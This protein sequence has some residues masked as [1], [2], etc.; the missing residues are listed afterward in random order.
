MWKVYNN[1]A[2]TDQQIGAVLAQLEEDGLLEETIIFFYADH[3]GPLPRQKRLIYDSG[4]KVPLIIRFPE[5]L[6][7]GIKDDQLVSFVERERAYLISRYA[8]H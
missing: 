5:S 6:D 2:E 8:G 7:A 3:G 4:L 1:L